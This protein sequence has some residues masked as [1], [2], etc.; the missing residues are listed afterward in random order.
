V[1]IDWRLL[2]GVDID[3]LVGAALQQQAQHRILGAIAACALEPKVPSWQAGSFP[4]NYCTELCLQMPRSYCSS[5]YQMH[6]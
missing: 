5:S 3:K 4:A 1:R 6:C 2:H